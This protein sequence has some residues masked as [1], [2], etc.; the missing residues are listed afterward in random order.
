MNT[1]RDVKLYMQEVF[2]KSRLDYT[3]KFNKS[4]LEYPFKFITNDC[5]NDK[6]PYK[7]KYIVRSFKNQSEEDYKDYGNF[8]NNIEEYYWI[9]EGSPNPR[10]FNYIEE[11]CCLCKL[12]NGKYAFFLAGCD[13]HGF[14][15]SGYM[16][17][18][19]SKSPFI[20]INY[21]MTER[22]YTLY[23]KDATILVL[24]VEP[25]IYLKPEN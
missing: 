19:V 6:S 12:N 25:E 7:N 21:A 9:Y 24:D 4:K 10:R 15:V 22:H 3:F 8:P 16:H 2:N 5:N 18:Y 14:D 23:K 20:L 17:L 13:K 1:E 11:W